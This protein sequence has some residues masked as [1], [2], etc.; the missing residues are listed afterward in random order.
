MREN[1]D[2]KQLQSLPVIKTK[3]GWTKKIR[4]GLSLLVKSDLNLGTLTS[5]LTLSGVSTFAQKPS[6]VGPDHLKELFEH[7]LGIIPKDAIAD[8]PLFLLATAGVRLLPELERKEL[9]K[10]ICSYTRSNTNFLLPDCDIHI[11]A[12]PGETEGLYGWI[13]AN[14]LLGGFDS[15][16]EHVHG[17]GHHTYGFLDMGGASAQIAFAPNATE[18]VRHA[19]DL[20]MLRLRTVDGTSAEYKV[21]VTTWLGFGVNEARKRYVEA[22]LEASGNLDI[23]EL[24]DPCLPTGLSIS[25]T[26]DILLPSDTI[27]GK[28][29]HLIGTGHFDE[30]LRKTYPLLD[31]DAP[32]EDQPC[33][34][35]G[36]HVPAIDFDVNHFVGV[37]EYWHTT[38]GIFEMAHKDKAYDF[39]TYQQRVDEFCSKDW[40]T[41]NKGIEAHTWGKK[42]DSQTA[43]E[44]CFKASWLINVLHEGIGIPRVGLEN[45]KT[46]SLNG[47]KEILSHAKEKGYTDSFQAVNKIADTEV[48]WTLG[49]ILLYASSEIPPPTSSSLP[50]GFGSNILG[51]PADFQYPGTNSTLSLSP[52]DLDPDSETPDLHDTL[53]SSATPRRLPGLILFVAILALGLYLLLGRDRRRSLF[54]KIPS[55]RRKYPFPFLSKLPFLS[56]RPTYDRILEEGTLAP[57]GDFELGVVDEDEYS[58]DSAGSKAERASG[59]ATPIVKGERFVART[60]SKE[61]LVGMGERSRRGSPAR[62]KRVGKVNE[63]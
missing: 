52:S 63:D 7:A 2:T 43:L 49:K 10:Q 47:T 20:K 14:Y 25:T 55:K 53:F 58:D 60:E 30:C 8:T 16:E 24:P 32:C 41:I 33:L 3:K 22:L 36:V 26:G 15:P 21:F 35:H 13:A 5:R 31:K 4:P 40:S 42:V 61:R 29:P 28:T 39:N 44:V 9:L 48:S 46:S 12:I 51:V 59:W 34:L 11:Q 45:T 18:A 54:H 6:L 37:S 62:W 27:H 23:D 50:V 38:H 19:E 1:A 57:P 56:P 17:K